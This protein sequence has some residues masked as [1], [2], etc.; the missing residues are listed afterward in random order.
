MQ[1]VLGKVLIW[2]KKKEKADFIEKRFSYFRKEKH[3]NSSQKKSFPF[4]QAISS[5]RKKNESLF[6]RENN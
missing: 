1:K 2:P 3:T 5:S 6:S 4:N